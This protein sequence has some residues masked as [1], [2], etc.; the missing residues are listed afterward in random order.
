MRVYA[1]APEHPACFPKASI[2]MPGTFLDARMAQREA[3][4]ELLAE[5][6]DTSAGR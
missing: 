2:F 4:R 3:A 5:L 1:P 6:E